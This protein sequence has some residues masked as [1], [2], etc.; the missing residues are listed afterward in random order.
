MST[1]A[2]QYILITIIPLVLGLGAFIVK[3]MMSRID[4]LEKKSNIYTSEPQVRQILGDKL[5][6][7]KEDLQDI[8]HSINKLFQLYFNKMY[9]KPPYRDD[10]DDDGK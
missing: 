2:L 5:D 7:I 6:P 10:N 8:K 4:E 3:S 1:E 9:S